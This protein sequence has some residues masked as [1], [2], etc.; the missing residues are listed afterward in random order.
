MAAS[1]ENTRLTDNFNTAAFEICTK[2]MK[3]FKDAASTF[4]KASSSY[5]SSATRKRG[6]DGEQG[7]QIVYYSCCSINSFD[8][9]KLEIEMKFQ[10]IREE[11]VQ[12]KDKKNAK[13]ILPVIQYWICLEVMNPKNKC[14]A[15]FIFK[16]QKKKS[17]LNS[18][19]L[20]CIDETGNPLNLQ[21]RNF[22]TILLSCTIIALARSHVINYIEVASS[23]VEKYMN[24]LLE[25]LKSQ[26]KSIV[27][28]PAHK[29][30]VLCENHGIDW[31]D[32]ANQAN[33]QL[34]DACQNNKPN[35]LIF[36]APAS[37]LLTF[38]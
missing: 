12:R 34:V 5:S 25:D 9:H 17:Y 21:G 11:I 13:S 23:M 1:F 33:K 32:I 16:W 22:A 18:N 24:Q 19:F 30:Y 35:P 6:L 28:I 14:D 20:K 38:T 26:K 2:I 36:Q 27:I 29:T 4:E 8:A 31:E 37:Y 10:I 3:H 15:D 7:K